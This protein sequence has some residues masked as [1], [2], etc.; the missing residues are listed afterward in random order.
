MR[1]TNICRNHWE[2]LM[3]RHSHKTRARKRDTERQIAQ[4]RRKMRRANEMTGQPRFPA[5]AL[6][7]DAQGFS[8][9]LLNQL[10]R[11]GMCGWN[12]DQ[13][14]EQ[15]SVRLMMMDIIS[16]FIGYHKL[17]LFP[18][19]SFIQSYLT[20]HQ[21][22]VTRILVFLVQSCH[23]Y[24]PPEELMP[25]VRVIADNFV[26]D[27][28]SP[29]VI[30]LGINTLSEIFLRIP[31]LFQM[32]ELEPL[33]HEVVEFKSNRDKGVVIA[34]RNFMNVGMRGLNDL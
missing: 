10:K 12:D 14:K 18:F 22:Q 17:C 7:Y 24:V 30:A 3:T 13:T 1:S 6:V 20:A 27:H 8:E 26:T 33:I 5:I 11:V 15:F 2:G 25:L 28:S 4:R 31:L 19:Y 16:R 21:Q 9:K 29:E 23:D 32:E 34:A